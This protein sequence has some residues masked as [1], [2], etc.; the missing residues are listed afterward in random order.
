MSFY[1]V[2]DLCGFYKP[3]SDWYR[4]WW[5]SAAGWPSAA[6]QV[7][8]S[9]PWHA[10]DSASITITAVAAAASLQ[11]SVN[12]IHVGARVPL[13]ALGFATWTV[14]F[15]AGNYTVLSYDASGAPLGSF[16]SITPGVP[17]ALSATVDWPGSAAGGALAAGRR[18]AALVAVLVVDDAGN[19]VPGAAINVSFALAGPGELLGLGNGDHLNH[20]P[21]S[22]IA[23]IPTYDGRCRA[24]L[25]S[26]AAASGLPIRL[27]VTAVGL[28]PSTVTINV[29]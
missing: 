22:G 10:G 13:A 8:A 18:D 6:T 29:V 7:L 15:A 26:A 1:G 9:P 19:R 28:M 23:T 25:R 12:G 20:L 5:G 11:L 24:V 14:P 3:V 27:T 17:V 2:L 16:V 4:V 21:G